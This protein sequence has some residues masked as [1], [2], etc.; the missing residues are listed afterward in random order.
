M[1]FIKVF[2]TFL[3]CL[4]AI[5]QWTTSCRKTER[6]PKDWIKDDLV[7]D[8]MDRLGTVAGFNLNDL[9]NFI[10][11]GFNRIGTLP[12]EYLDVAAGD[13]LPS[14]ANT[15]VE[16]YT[17]G[18]IN[19]L[20]NPDPY[21]GNSYAGIRRANIFLANIHKVPITVQTMQ[22]WKAEAR[23][24]RTLLYFELLKRYGGVPLVGDTVFKLDDDLQI[25]RNNFEQCVNYIVG[26][27]VAMRDS[28]RPDATLIDGDWG[29]I[30]RGAAVAL[31]C[32]VLLYAAS[33]LFNGGGFEQDA[34]RKALTGYPT[35]DPNR[36][37]KVIDAAEEF[38]S[39][40][41]YDLQASYL[42]IFTAKRNKEIILAKQSGNNFNLET[43]QAP[44][45][46]GT[47]AASQ[48]LTSPTQNLVDAFTTDAGLAINEAGSGYNA[49]APYTARDPRMNAII[50]Y[51]MGPKW[52]GKDIET[53][54]GGKDK[55]N[56]ANVPVQTKTGYYL[57]KF[58][59]DFTN[60]SSYSNQSHN[61][62]IF[63]YAEILLNYAEALNEMNRVE[64]AVTQLNLVRKRAGIKPG[65]N[66]RY[67]IKVG[68]NQTEMRDII[69]NERRVE[70]AF[71]EHRFWD[72]R[73]WKIADQALNGAINGM[74]ITKTGTTYTYQVQQV[75]TMVFQNRLYHMPIPYDETT[76]NLKLI[77]NEGW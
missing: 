6:E 4:S 12:G 14:R 60:G 62:P 61:F 26:E 16:Y 48:G 33:P 41:Y 55:P 53:F 51:N 2:I 75:G 58:L 37:Q 64:D 24:I 11:N 10:P 9:Y 73:R 7:F 45:G 25:P 76:K 47:P 1:K 31:K 28:L 27:C 57:R 40:G 3:I 56:V 63:R 32:R 5:T 65:A 54:E 72:V 21:W 18:R 71:E 30:T 23:F 69:R 35:A 29:R 74:K 39:I 66:N 59:G 8:T 20:N 34:T 77:Q 43:Y 36:W 22:F 13:A 42:T 15:T 17:N 49:S 70:L 44:V 46:Y 38:K 67:G 50:F 68:I 19:V 52:L